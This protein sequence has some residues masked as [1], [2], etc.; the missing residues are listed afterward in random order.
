MPT[1]YGIGAS[2]VLRAP[3]PSRSGVGTANRLRGT[4]RTIRRGLKPD[5]VLFTVPSEWT[6]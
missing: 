1:L 5:R 3:A 6:G 2:F 4:E